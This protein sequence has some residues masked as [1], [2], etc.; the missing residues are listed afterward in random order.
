[1]LHLFAPSPAPSNFPEAA[2]MDASF[3]PH[4]LLTMIHIIPGLLFMVLAPLQFVRRLRSRRPRLHRCMGRIVLA[5]G[6]IIGSTALVM[7]PQMAIGGANET[8]A[9]M[10]FA[11]IF[12]FALVKAFVSI[13]TGNIALHREWMIRA[14]AIGLAVA[15][16]RPIVGVFFAT[17]RLT[18]LTPHDFFGTA[19]W[20]GFTMHL[21]A[22]EIW[23][24]YT[25]SQS[26]VKEKPERFGTNERITE[27][28]AAGNPRAYL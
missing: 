17:R 7:S 27:G 26:R 16:I 25:R 28:L 1:M 21:I 23:I 6:L 14:F 15:T 12:L 9:T 24:N 11:V 19:F 8:V 18:H 2:A 3:A 13:R 10:F 4:R 20:L 5:S 22:A